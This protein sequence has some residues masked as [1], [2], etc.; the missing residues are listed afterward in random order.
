MGLPKARGLRRDIALNLFIVI[1]CF[2]G[3]L[4]LVAVCYQGVLSLIGRDLG[5]HP[6]RLEPRDSAR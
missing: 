6:M 4:G 3:T 5:G 2:I 1:L